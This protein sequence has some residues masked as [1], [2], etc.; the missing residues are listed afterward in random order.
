MPK[1]GGSRTDS[2][3]L[4][5]VLPCSLILALSLAPPETRGESAAGCAALIAILAMVAGA[6]GTASGPRRCLILAMLVSWPM[7]LAST[8][9]GKAIAAL[10]IWILAMAV[11]FSTWMLPRSAA[12]DRWIGR[13][14]VLVGTVVAGHGLY[15][16]F[17]GLPRLAADL[18]GRSD[19]AYHK[20]IMDRVLD[21]RAF[22]AFSTPAAMAGFLV[23]TLLITVSI[24]RGLSGRARLLWGSAILVQLAGLL[25]AAS[26]TALLSLAAAVGLAGIVGLGKGRKFVIAAVLVVV[27]G[28]A[29]I[30]VL[31]GAE[32]LDPSHGNNPLRLRAGNIRIAGEM[33]ADR[34]WVGTGPGGYGENYPAYRKPDD[35]E[36]MHVHNLPM[37]LVAEYGIPGGSFL[38]V[39][40]F[41]LFL[42]PLCRM[43]RGSDRWSGW[44]PGAAIGLAA[45]AIHNLADYTAFMPSLLWSSSLL[46]GLL[47]EPP[48]RSRRAGEEPAALVAVILAA[49][50]AGAGGLAWNARIGA[51]EASAAGDLDA[52]LAGAGRAVVL[53]PWDPD[54]RLLNGSLLLQAGKVP[55]AAG[56]AEAAIRLSP[57]RPS[58]RGMRS[59]VRQQSGDLAGAWCD[60]REAVR[61]YPIDPGYLRREEAMRS[62]ITGRIRDE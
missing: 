2:G 29:G 26:A 52:A 46:L 27:A 15:Q 33:A 36:S 48:V 45:F 21:G 37:E 23:L 4:Q 49:T 11:G 51:M 17:W 1:V 25:A 35:N 62:R 47:T 50:V 58:A 18:A 14:L 53:A 34:P 13:T 41:A 24:G 3:V 40:F 42:G 5:V 30:A 38:A 57:V 9:P 39:I 28:G 22:S 31:R 61:L 32:V 44:R 20:E 10:S 8:A 7:V 16:R 56:E 43:R 6:G 55:E 54:A 12:G 59:L 19:V 60:A